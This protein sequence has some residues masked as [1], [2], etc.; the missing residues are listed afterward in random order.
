MPPPSTGRLEGSTSDA[1]PSPRRSPLGGDAWNR[2]RARRSLD[3]AQRPEDVANGRARACA[4]SR[5]APSP[6]PPTRCVACGEALTGAYLVAPSGRGAHHEACLRCDLCHASTSSFVSVKARPELLCCPSCH[7]ATFAETCAGCR[8]VLRGGQATLRAFDRPWHAGCF[9]CDLCRAPHPPGASFIP[10][11]ELPG[12][13]CAR[14]HLEH[15][16]PK[17]ARCGDGVADVHH[18]ALG[19]TYHRGCFRCV[20]CDADVASSYVAHDGEPWCGRCHVD[21]H[22]PRCGCGCGRGVEGEIVRALGRKFLAACFR[23][24]DCRRPFPGGSFVDASRSSSAASAASPRAGG[25]LRPTFDRTGTDSGAERRNVLRD[26]V[27]A[28]C[29]ATN[30]AERCAAC[31]TPL[32]DC[33]FARTKEWGEAMCTA[34]ET[35]PGSVCDDCGRCVKMGS[36][37]GAH[38]HRSAASP[39]AR[40]TR[41]RRAARRRSGGE[42][43]IGQ[44]DA[45]EKR[46]VTTD[47]DA[48]KLFRRVV[49]AMA[50]L[51]AGGVAAI[52]IV[53]GAR[54]SASPSGSGS[55]PFGG[56]IPEGRSSRGS[57]TTPA[58][59][60]ARDGRPPGP[61][62]RTIRVSLVDA[63]ALARAAKKTHRGPNAA[64]PRGV[65][66]T[67]VALEGAAPP[68]HWA[69]VVDGWRVAR[70]R[71]GEDRSGDGNSRDD[72]SVETTPRGSRSPRVYS[73]SPRV[74]SN[75]P[76]VSSSPRALLRRAS[77]ARSRPDVTVRETRELEGVLALRGASDVALGAVLAH[78][79]AHGLFFLDEYPPMRLE[80]EEGLCELFAW[81]WLSAG[82]NGED[83]AENAR[84]RRA[85]E[86][87]K[88]PVYGDGFR[89]ALS[90][91]REASGGNLENLLARV[92][93][94][95]E[96]PSA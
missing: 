49:A 34:C 46:A 65:T 33:R 16:A 78:E 90:A 75:S 42:A 11:G 4:A 61:A 96:L 63:D 93:E 10:R 41:G 92:R 19:R 45:C 50:D 47:E 70:R 3:P 48:A 69:A 43:V 14:C 7:D 38:H 29:Y 62:P 67:R 52:E 36:A 53:A 12:S 51:G 25:D 66:C 60:S 2:R 27:C 23:C 20:R 76:R 32:V 74:C 28:S 68:E 83:E 22:A 37:D 18:V 64:G 8:G 54:K 6:P 21:A 91:F 84:R 5:A 44:C 81:L 24:A 72:P 31:A 71:P 95:G 39:S 94:T 1:R 59:E 86:E 80:T 89:A 85:M 15:V 13:V 87:R 79:Y 40:K 58:D 26:V 82:R 56:G 88:D 73:N 30:R 17:C 55:S 35:R 9:A 57:K 77:A